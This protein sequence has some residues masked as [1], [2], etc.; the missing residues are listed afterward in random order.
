MCG[1][2]VCGMWTRM[3]GAYK[4]LKLKKQRLSLKESKDKYESGKF[5]S[6]ECIVE[7]KSSSQKTT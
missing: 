3:K 7:G 4:A 2:Y 1:P 6:C 5:K